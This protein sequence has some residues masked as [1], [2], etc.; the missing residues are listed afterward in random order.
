MNSLLDVIV[1]Q[2]NSYTQGLATDLLDERKKFS[3][4][5]SNRA[6]KEDIREPTVASL[7]KCTTPNSSSKPEGKK[8]IFSKQVKVRWSLL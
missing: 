6:V 1:K 7:E 8:T 4:F 5:D 3:N 2:T